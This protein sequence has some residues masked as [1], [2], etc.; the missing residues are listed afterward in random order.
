MPKKDVLVW[1]DCEMTGLDPQQ[2]TILEA[3]AIITDDKLNVIAQLGPLVIH[4]TAAQLAAMN[5]WC[6]KQHKTSGL[7]QEALE[8]K[9]TLLQAE[10]QLLT[11]IKKHSKPQSSPLCGNSI[12]QDRSFLRRY[13]PKVNEYLHYRIIDVSS[14]K[15]II[16]RQHGEKAL[17]KK[18]Q[19]HR[20]LDDITESIAEMR[21]Y[22]KRFLK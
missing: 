12:W 9:L 3:S 18:K 17:L 7:T 1:M 14:F 2:D 15:E 13:M 10:K 16:R 8:S 22:L 5:T 20:S 6:K 4:H 21:Y 19:T 11:F